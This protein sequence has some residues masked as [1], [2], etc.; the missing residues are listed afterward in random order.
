MEL[1][2]EEKT[3]DLVMADDGQTAAGTAGTIIRPSPSPKEAC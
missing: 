1:H 3:V 2:G